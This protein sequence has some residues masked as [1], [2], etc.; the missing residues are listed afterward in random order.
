VKSRAYGTHGEA[1]ATSAL[2]ALRLALNALHRLFAPFLPFV[3]DEMWTWWQ[4]SSV[5]AQPWPI[6]DG[7]WGDD[8]LLAPVSEVLALVRRAKTEAKASQKADVAVLTVHA[9]AATNAT[10]AAAERDLRD[11][12]SVTELRYVESTEL[13]CEVVLAP[14]AADVT[15]RPTTPTTSG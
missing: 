14:I 5:H 1:D 10:I 13:S 7:T 12:G 9:P 6:V 11:A 8:A 3:A 15:G 4:A 2:A